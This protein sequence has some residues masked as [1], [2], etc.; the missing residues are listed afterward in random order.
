MKFFNRM[1]GEGSRGRKPRLPGTVEPSKEKRQCGA[2]GCDEEVVGTSLPHHYRNNTDFNKL[3][4]LRRLPREQAA[5]ELESLD[6]H[7]RYMFH[8]NHSA[9]YLP[10][11][12]THKKVQKPAP[13]F[14]Q[15]PDL[16]DNHDDATETQNNGDPEPEASSKRSHPAE[17]EDDREGSDREHD[18]D[19]KRVR[20]NS[21][22]SLAIS[23]DEREVKAKSES[24]VKTLLEQ[25]TESLK[26]MGG[27]N[28]NVVEELS[29]KIALKTARKT[30]ELLRIES[31]E[32]EKVGLEESW[33]D[34]DPTILCRPCMK[35]ADED[36]IPK[37]LSKSRRGNF[38]MIE[39]RDG[40]GNLR[41]KTEVNSKMKRHLENPLHVYCCDREKKKEKLEKSLAE[42]NQ[43]AGR[44]T[45]RNAIQTLKRGGGQQKIFRL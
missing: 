16:N 42:S 25:I 28:D 43:A 5:E 24:E 18:P 10:H 21:E 23:D 30:V 19:D 33:I 31:E 29:E 41:K 39:R 4:E 37:G 11:W 35:F 7:M 26:K 27:L 36:D 9:S 45:I 14:F 44:I 8:H 12:R 6:C 3:G 32:A 1:V 20:F 22:E 13:R 15:R 38:G 2:V 40:E 17:E 34:G